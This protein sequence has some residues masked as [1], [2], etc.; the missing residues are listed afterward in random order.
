MARIITGT[1][2]SDKADKTIVLQTT[3]RKTHP[4]YKKQY[5]RTNKFIA[6]DEHN[7]AR[8]GDIVRVKEVRP[9]SKRKR[10]TLE[11]VVQRAEIAE[12]DRVENITAEDEAPAKV[13]K[14]SEAK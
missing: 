12:S 13:S 5:T 4:L 14:E 1:V 8:V 9:I 11:E 6:H 2:V 3:V 7:E 10:L